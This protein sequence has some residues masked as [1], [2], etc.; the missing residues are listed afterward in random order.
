MSLFN[1]WANASYTPSAPKAQ[2]SAFS[3]LCLRFS[4]CQVKPENVCSNKSDSDDV[5]RTHQSFFIFVIIVLSW[6]VVLELFKAGIIAF[7]FCRGRGIVKQ[8]FTK[9]FIRNS[10]LL[11]LLGWTGI[12]WWTE[13]LMLKNTPS[14]HLIYFFYQCI[15][16]QVPTVYIFLHF[17]TNI[18]Q[19]LTHD[20]S[21]RCFAIFIF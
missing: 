4:R 16:V 2:E 7:S 6:I 19:V 17:Y 8:E 11:P 15:T 1:L 13:V 5:D 14:D 10:F 12:D 20:V 18:I 9:H 21:D 3:H